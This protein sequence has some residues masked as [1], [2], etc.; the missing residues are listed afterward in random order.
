MSSLRLRVF[1]FA[2]QVFTS[3]LMHCLLRIFP[4]WRRGLG[5]AKRYSSERSWWF[6]LAK[7]TTQYLYLKLP[8]QVYRVDD[9][10][11]FPC[12]CLH[13]FLEC[14]SLCWD[15]SKIICNSVIHFNTLS[16]LLSTMCQY[17]LANGPQT[18]SSDQT[19]FWMR[20]MQKN[21]QKIR[22]SIVAICH[23]R[24]VLLWYDNHR[25]FR[26]VVPGA[27]R[28]Q[29]K[30]ILKRQSLQP[31]PCTMSVCV[32]LCLVTRWVSSLQLLHRSLARVSCNTLGFDRLKC[33]A[34][35]KETNTIQGSFCLGERFNRSFC[36]WLWF[37]NCKEHVR[38]RCYRAFMALVA[39]ADF[40][41]FKIIQHSQIS[42]GLE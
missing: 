31:R 21:Q 38:W 24:S 35:I 36:Q 42:L 37:Q 11:Y 32:S 7:M 17:V 39:M 30:H 6:F 10:R 14:G 8:N 22:V 40:S 29:S 16:I 23:S 2:L 4:S 18:K 13:A 28:T 5:G 26:I 12:R 34:R 25:A 9:G 20:W 1:T 19:T 33:M 15:Y 41:I 27:T 3:D